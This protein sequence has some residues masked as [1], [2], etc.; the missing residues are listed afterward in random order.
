MIA[1]ALSSVNA[2]QII[3][4][5]GYQIW[6]ASIFGAGS[7]LD[8]Y[9][10]SMAVPLL[11]GSSVSI[12]V[13][14]C[15]VPTFTEIRVT[16]GERT[17]W[18]VLSGVVVCVAAALAALV[19][20]LV[21]I[22]PTVIALIAPGLP[23][24][25]AHL[26]TRLLRIQAVSVVTTGL[27]G[28]FEGLA[29]ARARFL[30]VGLSQLTGVVVAWITL[31]LTVSSWGIMGAA[32]A[33]VANSAATLVILFD[34]TWGRWRM[35]RREHRHRVMKVLR[36]SLPGMLSSVWRNAGQIVDR[37]IGSILP[38]GTITYLAYAHRIVVVLSSVAARGLGA[39]GIGELSSLASGRDRLAFITRARE[40]FETI[41]ALS[42][43]LSV[44]LVVFGV[45][46]FE[47]VFHVGRF[48]QQDAHMLGLTTAAFCGILLGGSMS[49]IVSNAFY[50]LHDTRT[51]AAVTIVTF[52]AGLGLKVFGGMMLGVIGVALGESVYY[53]AGLAV[54]LVAFHR[55]H[56]SDREFWTVLARR[57]MGTATLVAVSV[58]FGWVV[59]RL[60]PGA[61]GA[62]A[63]SLVATVL[64]GSLSLWLHPNLRGRVRSVFRLRTIREGGAALPA[65]E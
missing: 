9:F 49:T 37:F 10:V 59:L 61:A 31:H 44:V 3:L 38:T 14:V 20:V 60:V 36:D 52:T 43:P 39:T 45:P 62:V 7:E 13:G 5:L 48:S 51:P 6:L 50:A 65:K 11:I 1:A 30:A 23:P 2:L 33:F 15:V 22:A 41:L 8:A 21:L 47:L 42:L 53:L 57:S 26:A 18:E 29:L 17:A 28:V 64:Y 58:L 24:E 4:S 25:T 40:Q 55:R 63:G 54:L 46:L 16:I 56:M 12:G 34:N 35:P 32:V 27:F 19:G